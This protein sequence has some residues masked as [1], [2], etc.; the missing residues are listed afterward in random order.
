MCEYLIFPDFSY[1]FDEY[2]V[3]IT[4]VNV[5][6]SYMKKSQVVINMDYPLIK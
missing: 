3:I 1:Y 2:N 5:G 4:D 6:Q